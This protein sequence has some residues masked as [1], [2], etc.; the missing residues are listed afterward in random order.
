MTNINSILKFSVCFFIYFLLYGCK[1]S[2]T[3]GLTNLNNNQITVLGHR[4][5]GASGVDNPYPDNTLESMEVGIDEL[6]ADGIEMDVQLSKDNY[7]MLH[8]NADLN[9]ATTCNGKINTYP[10]DELKKCLINTS[11]YNVPLK[12]YYLATLEEV[13]ERFKNYSP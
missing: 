8:H 2:D 13:F 10:K 1:K 5:S 7:L 9:S 6:G 3:E 12:D 11:F 4:G